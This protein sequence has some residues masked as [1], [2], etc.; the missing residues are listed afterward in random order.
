MNKKMADKM[1]KQ[2]FLATLL[3]NIVE[4]NFCDEIPDFVTA[5]KYDTVN[6]LELYFS[7][8]DEWTPELESQALD[9]TLSTFAYRAG[10][11]A[12]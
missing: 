9:I 12:V 3:N 10:S 4:I 2:T 1:E 7:A 5:V 8:D 11:I 6:D